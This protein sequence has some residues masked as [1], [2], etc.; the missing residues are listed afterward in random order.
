MTNALFCDLT[1]CSVLQMVVPDLRREFVSEFIWP[2]IQANA[3]YEDRYLLGTALARPL[4]ARS[5][6]VAYSFVCLVIIS[7]CQV[8]VSCLLVSLPRYYIFK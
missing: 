2:A 8:G 3:K 5:A 7:H 1:L 4:I 6:S